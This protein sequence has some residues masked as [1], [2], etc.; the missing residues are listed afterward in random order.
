MQ[1]FTMTVVV[2]E[3]RTWASDDENAGVTISRETKGAR[4][5]TFGDGETCSIS[6]AVYLRGEQE[7]RNASGMARNLEDAT[8]RTAAALQMLRQMEELE[9]DKRC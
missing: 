1:L 6:W 7:T 3:R 8:G 5:I 2:E 4:S 9:G